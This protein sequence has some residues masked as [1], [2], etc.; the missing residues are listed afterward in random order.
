MAAI[1][2]ASPLDAAERHEV[3]QP[4]FGNVLF[5]YFQ[6]HYFSSLTSLMT[7]QHFARLGPHADE[8]EL[9]RGGILLSYGSHEEAG[10]IFERLIAEGAPPAVRDRAWFYLAK[11]RY[12]RGYIEQAEDA[13]AR[14]AGPLPGELE[15][16]R[17]VLHAYLLIQRQQY[18]EAIEMLQRVPPRSPWA[19]YGRYNLGVALIKAGER[20][21]G[22][23]LLEELGKTPAQ[24]DELAT[25]KDKANVALAYSFLQ[26]EQGARARPYLERVRLHG[27]L[28]NK[29]LLGMGWAHTT[30]GEH[31]R[32]LVP[33]VELADR[34]AV[35]AAVQESLLAV[36]YAFG[37][38]GA[39]RQ[40]LERYEAALEIYT[41]ESARLDEAI[42][43]IRAGKLVE[44]ILR[45]NPADE[46][47]WFFR[48][49]HPPDA[50]EARYLTELLASHAF[51]EALKN[52]R[53][54]RFLQQN[55]DNW[56]GKLTSYHD[57]VATRRQ[58]YAERLPR[59]LSRERTLDVQ[60]LHAARE[61]YS[62]ELARIERDG[63]AAALAND[64]EKA[65]LERLGRVERA[66]GSAGDAEA[67]DKHRRYRG[68]LAWDLSSQYSARLWEAKKGMQQIDVLL[69]EVSGRRETLERAQIDAPQSF[70]AFT[71]RIETQRRRIV[72]LRPGVDAVA[73][74]Q[75]Q[76]L[77]E[78]AADELTLQ[79]E[80]I[81]AYVTQ[82]RFAVA[83][84]YDQAVRAEETKQ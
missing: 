80:R 38:L 24:G 58:A 61:E 68:L 71:G 9:L 79:R 28:S 7:E 6:E 39:Y 55:L 49:R 51:Q 73:R 57:M 75:E 76:H 83:Q 44:N 8:A 16:E 50:P 64:K 59:A 25:L 22:V 23:R 14:I 81:A 27:L 20:E 10:R 66:L 42:A 34:N 13:I 41:R 4:H 74:A 45:A 3:K 40:S 11:I 84:I 77:A 72:Q 67:R 65:L 37:K 62:A 21:S 54:L 53:D 52:Y 2:G 33:W 48:M 31:Q 30:Q 19:V 26:E 36:P 69:G 56:E 46:A 43:A 18:K 1:V 15:D 17:R 32:A 78:L 29:A 60:R 12:Q 35:D 5:E 47:G 82:A 63:D 70:E